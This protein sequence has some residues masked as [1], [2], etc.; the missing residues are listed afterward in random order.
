MKFT[1]RKALLSFCAT[2]ICTGF[3]GQLFTASAQKLDTYEGA[4]LQLGDN[5]YLYNSSSQFGRTKMNRVNIKVL[6]AD[7]KP[8]P[9]IIG[10]GKDA[11]ARFKLHTYN[12]TRGDDNEFIFQGTEL[13]KNDPKVTRPASDGEARLFRARIKINDI[14]SGAVF[15]FY[16][17]EPDRPKTGD[18]IDNE[19]VGAFSPSLWLTLHKDGNELAPDDALSSPFGSSA[20]WKRFNTYT[21]RWA[22]NEV[23]WH[24]NDVGENAPTVDKPG[25]ANSNITKRSTSLVPEAPLRL[26]LNTWAPG[27]AESGWRARRSPTSNW[28]YAYQASL[29]PATN[30]D[31]NETY[32]YD[33]K[34]VQIGRTGSLKAVGVAKSTVN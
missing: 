30:R 7:K 23:T 9:E 1:T 19:F 2:L 15:G 24:I 17:V 4:N 6:N 3:G 26:Q 10:T 13:T 8:N 28:M 12:P 21:F 25:V 18:E 32:S 34:W 5:W 33:V 27:I 14:L 29:Q 20:D 11:V 16:A 31:A 22:R